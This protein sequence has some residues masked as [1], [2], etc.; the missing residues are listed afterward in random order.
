MHYEGEL[1][2][3]DIP[4]TDWREYDVEEHHPDIIFIMYPYDDD[5]Y[6]TSLNPA[7]YSTH[8]KR[9]CDLLA[10]VPYF[11][12]IGDN[13]EPAFCRAAGALN[14]DKVFLQSEAV[15]QKYIE[16]LKKFE[17]EFNCKGRFGKPEDKYVALGS[18]KF[19]AVINAKP[20]DF[21][22]PDSWRALIERA[23]RTKKKV[24]FYNTT[25]N[26]ILHGNEQYLKK[27]RSVLEFFKDRD[28][29]VLWWR[30]HPL[31]EATYQSMRPSLLDEYESIVA[32]YK[33]ARYGIFDDTPELQR[34]IMLSYAYY[35]DWSSVVSLYGTTRKPIIIQIVECPG[36]LTDFY[37]GDSMF[38]V[39]NGRLTLIPR[40]RHALI[41]VELETFSAQYN[42]LLPDKPVFG[43]QT[44][45]CV[46]EGEGK[47]Y[48]IHAFDDEIFE[49]CHETGDYESRTIALKGDLMQQGVTNFAT[50]RL[51][52]H[53]LYLFPFGYGAII[54]YD[55]ADNS[56]E[57]LL[58]LREKHPELLESI[59]FI[60]HCMISDETALLIS[61]DTNIVLEFHLN[62]HESK[63][64]RLGK[65]DDCFGY[66]VKH[67][68]NIWIQVRNRPAFIRWDYMSDKTYEYSDFHVDFINGNLNFGNKMIFHY[69]DS[70][71]CF[72]YQAN[73]AVVLD[74]NTG[75]IKRID[76][77]N[78]FC[79]RNDAKTSIKVLRGFMHSD[80]IYLY[81][82]DGLLIEYNTLNDK[83]RSRAFSSC[84]YP[85]TM[86]RI[87]D[88]ALKSLLAGRE[89]GIAIPSSNDNLKGTAGAQIY[90]YCKNAVGE[91]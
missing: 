40:W 28:D 48:F 38:S 60:H 74:L 69:Q 22:L 86:Q 56:T 6:I 23:D 24:I 77:F 35:G 41:T 58:T 44:Y 79:Y 85:E 73:M 32:E 83:I 61:P 70:L 66:I 31:H 90:D 3:D 17:K 78:T 30:P 8:L 4:I 12:S 67:G 14:A 45:D 13:V 39:H 63:L 75:L 7:Y 42:G 11:V 16:E 43:R 2:P 53:N 68:L 65:K 27:L 64:H 62:S 71:Y 25:V 91:V 9:C 49:Y 5:N 1:Y 81:S 84:L 59:R 29:V 47:A 88:D 55:L 26:A 15:R 20:E 80:I 37:Y 10:Y 72:P 18:T 36:F 50:G 33:R 51:V 34:G 89:S 57:H 82:C 21:A 76:A 46:I 87:S 54:K 19:D 52:D